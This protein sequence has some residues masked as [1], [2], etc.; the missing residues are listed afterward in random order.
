[1]VCWTLCSPI[2]KNSSK[3]TVTVYAVKASEDLQTNRSHFGEPLRASHKGFDAWNMRSRSDGVPTMCMIICHDV[4]TVEEIRVSSK[5]GNQ[6][7]TPQESL[8]HLPKDIW[9]KLG[10]V[11]P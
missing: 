1:M 5:S 2:E 3:L 7:V 4:A 8:L 11:E 6:F 10:D 9:P